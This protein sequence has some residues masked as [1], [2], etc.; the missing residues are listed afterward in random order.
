MYNS[1]GLTVCFSMLALAITTSCAPVALPPGDVVGD[2]GD[3]APGIAGKMGDPLPS[4]TPEQLAT[5]ER[6]KSVFLK[7]F[8]LAEGL[9][10]A[11]NVSA[12]GACHERPT[13]GGSAGVPAISRSR[14]TGTR[15]EMSA[16]MDRER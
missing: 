14:T 4:A 16:A 12:C 5:F 10:P 9:G 15:A 1:L 3:I 7:R 13:P 8:D 6:G 11:F 2:D